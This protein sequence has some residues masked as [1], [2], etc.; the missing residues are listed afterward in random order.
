[1]YYVV[2]QPGGL[3]RAVLLIVAYCVVHEAKFCECAR[4]ARC[5]CVLSHRF[6]LAAFGSILLLVYFC[7]SIVGNEDPPLTNRNMWPSVFCIGQSVADSDSIISGAEMKRHKLF[8]LIDKRQNLV[9]PLDYQVP[10]SV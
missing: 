9:A 8:I 3:A 6:Y 1:M 2:V 7:F 10:G 4:V 5:P